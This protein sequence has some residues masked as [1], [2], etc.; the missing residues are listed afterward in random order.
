MPPSDLLDDPLRN[1]WVGCAWPIVRN[2]LQVGVVFLLSAIA[3]VRMDSIWVFLGGMA[4]GATLLTILD[5][6]V[7]QGRRLRERAASNR[8]LGLPDGQP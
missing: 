8:L 7:Y 6:T 1:A 5:R 2:F 3:A 4:L